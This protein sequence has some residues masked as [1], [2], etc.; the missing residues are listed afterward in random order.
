MEEGIE[1]NAH[2]TRWLELRTLAFTLQLVVISLGSVLRRRT[3][4]RLR[5]PGTGGG[6]GSGGGGGGSGSGGRQR[7]TRRKKQSKRRARRS[8]QRRQ[9]G[10][11][12]PGKATAAAAAQQP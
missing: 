11:R 5:D 2:R 3:Q 6:G 8:P 12:D 4:P 1:I 7:K 9:L 10:L